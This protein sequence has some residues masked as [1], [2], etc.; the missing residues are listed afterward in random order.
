M[1]EST[2]T[3]DTLSYLHLTENDLPSEEGQGGNTEQHRLQR[4]LL[5]NSLKPWL[6]HQGEG[7][8][9]GQ[10]F[11]HFGNQL[12]HH[13]E[14]LV[15]DVFIVL[16][17]SNQVRKNWVVWKEGK[18]PEV[19]IEL[20]SNSTLKYD[21]GDKKFIY[22]NHLQIPE[23]YW[24]NPNNPEDWA[25]FELVNGE[26]QEIPIDAHNRFIS[27][28]LGLALTRWHGIYEGLEAIW[29]RWAT[30]QGQFLP[31]AQELVLAAQHRAEMAT[32]CAEAEATARRAAEERAMA[33]EEE[34]ARL[35]NLLGNSHYVMLE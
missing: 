19:V 20:L 27:S 28:R 6:N 18:S 24:F 13:Y 23:Y 21:K 34:L 29:L 32:Q 35:K 31:T 33:M 12:I 1:L 3:L 9:S 8:I 4:E 5:I 2:T 10:M 17:V 14:S 15:P 7:Y 16:E 11:I 30:V 25:G 26:Y 22:Q